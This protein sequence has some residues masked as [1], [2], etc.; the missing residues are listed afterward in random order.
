MKRKH[1]RK[2]AFKAHKTIRAAR[3]PS[4]PDKTTD[5][6]KN[7]L[8]SVLSC[9]SPSLYVLERT[10]D[11]IILKINSIDDQVKTIEIDQVKT[12]VNK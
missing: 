10:T 12:L 2:H 9:S 7:T 4:C 1:T 11:T 3:I 5:K 8:T 6:L